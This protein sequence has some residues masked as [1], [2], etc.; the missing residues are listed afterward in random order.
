MDAAGG[1][2]R[3]KLDAAAVRSIATALN[4][5]QAKG[6]GK[7]NI[8]PV[9]V[10]LAVGQL[11]SWNASRGWSWMFGVTAVPAMVF[12]TLM[13]LVP[14]SP[15]W[16]AKNGKPERAR[17]VLA[18]VGGPA[19]A[20]Q[21]LA[22]IE[23]TLVGEI[24]R[25]NFG[26]LLEPGVLKI[27]VLGATLAFLQQ[28]CGMNVI[29]YY[30]S[31]I[32]TAAGYN[33]PEAMRNIV[34]IGTVM[35]VFTIVAVSSVDR[36]GRRGLMLIGFAGIARAARADRRQLPR[37]RHGRHGARADALGNRV[38]QLHLGAGHLGR[39]FRDFS[40][41]HPRRRDVDLGVRPLDRLLHADLQLPAPEGLARPRW[42]VSYLL[43]NLPGRLCVHLPPPAGNQRQDP[44]GA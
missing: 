37:T 3:R 22:S 4:D 44:G 1:R 25:V 34:V 42:N 29:F 10:D 38:L 7:L 39:A 15:R 24:E 19:H 23:E 14:E 5:S 6:K 18:R 20:A 43:G 13:F 33:V 12:F 17:A 41:P 30:A 27:I 8:E 36:F 40:Q 2:A 32:F 9:A 35:V 21:E 16:L 26:D 28:W 11:V 31:D